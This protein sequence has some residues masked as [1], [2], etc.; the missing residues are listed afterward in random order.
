MIVDL[1]IDNKNLK[2]TRRKYEDRAGKIDDGLFTL[3]CVFSV[4]IDCNHPG[5]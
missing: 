5:E 3:G 1:V 2:S 4:V